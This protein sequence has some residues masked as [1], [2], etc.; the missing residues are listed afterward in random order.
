MLMDAVNYYRTF[1]PLREVNRHSDKVAC[2]VAGPNELEGATDND[3]AGTDIFQ[4]CRLYQGPWAFDRFQDRVH[5]MGAVLAFDSDDDLTERYR[6]VSG[7]QSEFEYVLSNA[8]YVTTSTQGLADL[9]GEYSK[10]PPI[11]LQN[12]VDVAWMQEIARRGASA[13]ELVS[14]QGFGSEMAWKDW[15][16]AKQWGNQVSVGMS[17]SPTHYGDWMQ[18]AI[19]LAGARNCLRI[20]HGNLPRYMKYALDVAMPP[21]PFSVYPALLAQFDI[22]LCAVDARDHYNDGKSDVK[23]LEAMALGVVPICSRFGPYVELAEAGA[24]VI[25]LDGETPGDWTEAIEG[26]LADEDS[27]QRLSDAGPEW[28]REHRDM[29]TTGYRQWDAFYQSVVGS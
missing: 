27:R 9:F 23:A 18:A 26:L 4:M 10:R 8:D 14:V 13:A 15:L 22:L 5:S 19:G 11:V 20:A 2:R 1:L 21:V 12:C 28:V 6:L 25:I 3:F 24:P 16:S 17:G 7:R 29:S